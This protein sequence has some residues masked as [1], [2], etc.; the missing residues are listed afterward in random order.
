VGLAGV[1]EPDDV[2]GRYKGRHGHAD[3]SGMHRK[4]VPKLLDSHCSTRRVI[5]GVIPPPGLGSASF[6]R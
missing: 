5:R 4:T 3:D 2:G 1:A 6:V